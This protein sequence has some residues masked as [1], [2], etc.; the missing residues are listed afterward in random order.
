MTSVLAL[1]TVFALLVVTGHMEKTS[2]AIALVSDW[3]IDAYRCVLLAIVLR[4]S[5]EDLLC[6]ILS[7]MK[8]DI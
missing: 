4:C 2:E 5:T 6:N 3:K 7:I 1:V 8:S